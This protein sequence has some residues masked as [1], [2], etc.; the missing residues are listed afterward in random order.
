[1]I[2]QDL[3]DIKALTAR[4]IMERSKGKNRYVLLRSKIKTTL[5]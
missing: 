3:N 1:M 5:K 4:S 2:L